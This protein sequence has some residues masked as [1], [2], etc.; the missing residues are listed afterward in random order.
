MKAIIIAKQK[1]RG[2]RAARTSFT[3]RS[4]LMLSGGLK[5]Y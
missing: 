2:E 1:L 4:Y 5:S 3:P